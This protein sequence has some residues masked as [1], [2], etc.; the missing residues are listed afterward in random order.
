MLL[1]CIIIL[2]KILFF[3]RYK[4][5]FFKLPLKNCKKD[6]ADTAYFS[7]AAI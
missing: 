3:N 5:F 4:G 1:F 6:I 2:L 7:V